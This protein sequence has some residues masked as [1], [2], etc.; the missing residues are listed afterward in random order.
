LT[1]DPPGATIVAM[2]KS[3]AQLVARPPEA[4]RFFNRELSWMAFNA[5]VLAQAQD[6]RVPLLER[7][8]FLTIFH[9]NLD[10]FFMIRVSGS[11]SRS[12]PRCP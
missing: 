2:S 7:L 5:R 3:P 4:A 1:Q 9:T 12:P 11:S 8:R 10:E 6:A